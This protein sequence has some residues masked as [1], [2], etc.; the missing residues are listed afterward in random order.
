MLCSADCFLPRVE[1]VCCRASAHGRVAAMQVGG[2]GAAHGW[3]P[4]AGVCGACGTHILGLN[5]DA[6]IQKLRY[7]LV[8]AVGCR[9]EVQ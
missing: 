7:L 3:E 8:I 6:T 1:A 9:I 2:A 5:G 4:R